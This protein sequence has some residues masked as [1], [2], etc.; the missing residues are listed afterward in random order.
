MELSE[1][2]DQLIKIRAAHPHKRLFVR[3]TVNMGEYEVS[4]VR[5]DP[6]IV[7]SAVMLYDGDYE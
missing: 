7:G 1:L 4:V 2:I 6:E 5:V 3:M